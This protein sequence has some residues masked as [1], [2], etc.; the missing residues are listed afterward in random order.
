MQKDEKTYSNDG[1]FGNT[2]YGSP[3]V[4]KG[5]RCAVHLTQFGEFT[6]KKILC[7][8]SGNGYEAVWFIKR[9]CKVTIA[10]IYQPDVNIL[11]GTQVKAYAQ[12]LPF[13]DNEFD[14]VFCCEVMEHVSIENTVPILKEAKRVGRN[15][16]FTIADT[17]DPPY[18]THI[19]IHGFTFW[20]SLFKN[21]GF[22]IL[23]AQ[24]RPRI[25][26]LVAKNTVW[27][28]KYKDGI[29]IYAEC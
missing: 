1:V 23:N 25:P 28:N 6:N 3:Y 12:D 22:K 13:R 10:D 4:S 8:G 15:V 26:L 9:G 24:H 2:R 21:L 7:I 29:L 18:N 20:Y 19:N 11:K 16:F 14:L 27:F 17:P 5:L